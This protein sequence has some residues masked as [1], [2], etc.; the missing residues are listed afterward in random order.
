MMVVTVG[1]LAHWCDFVEMLDKSSVLGGEGSDDL[2]VH[3]PINFFS[4]DFVPVEFFF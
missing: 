2:L 4:S 1:D 3:W